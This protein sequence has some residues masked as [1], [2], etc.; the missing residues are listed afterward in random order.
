MSKVIRELKELAQNHPEF[1]NEL[2]LRE[3]DIQLQILKETNLDDY[4]ALDKAV[5]KTTTL[6]VDLI[7]KVADTPELIEADK[8]DND[9]PDKDIEGYLVRLES[10]V[11]SIY[12]GDVDL[13]GTAK[14]CL[15]FEDGD[16][17]DLGEE[18]EDG[19]LNDL[20]EEEEDGD[21][22]DLGEEEEDGN[23]NDLGEEEPAEEVAA[24]ASEMIEFRYVDVADGF[25][26]MDSSEEGY[27]K[28][29]TDALIE[30]KESGR[31]VP[32]WI[33]PSYERTTIEALVRADFLRKKEASAN[34]ELQE[35]TYTSNKSAKYGC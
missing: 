12:A 6:L 8:I 10:S 15:D 19:D 18:E 29:V 16:L 21:L 35:E 30:R 13:V 5:K 14:E 3:L 33:Q 25:S 2:S 31:N 17:N 28:K 11:D 26:I 27:V 20:G 7:A 1:V 9:S 34:N 32:D 4:P 22:N 24:P 23:L